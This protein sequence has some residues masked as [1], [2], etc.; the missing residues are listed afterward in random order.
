MASLAVIACLIVVLFVGVLSVLRDLLTRDIYAP[1]DTQSLH[2][3]IER[4]E[5]APLQKRSTAE[6]VARSHG[7]RVVT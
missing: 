4:S 7:Q 6:S 5:A 1:P 2:R 3:T